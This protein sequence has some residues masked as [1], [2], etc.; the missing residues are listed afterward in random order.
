[1]KSATTR[2][3]ILTGI[4]IP[5]IFWGS[6]IIGASLHGNYNHFKDTI[7]QLGATGTRSETFMTVATWVCVILSV[8]F[9][10]G[11]LK[12]SHH[13]QI[14]KLPLIGV[15]GFT[16]IFGWAA[17]FHSGH[18][19]HSRSGPLLLLLLAGPLLTLILWKGKE[20][21]TPR[22]LSILS[23][24]FMLLILL[25]VVL[26]QTIRDNY[27]GLI[28]RSVHFGW[29]IWFISLVITFLPLT[30]KRSDTPGK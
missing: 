24:F 2:L 19:M 14:N 1:V 16:L 21:K 15:L 20:F 12:A 5:I 4:F 3:L 10:T 30:N 29:T 27:T 25:R 6:T 13:L 17:T 22:L 23:L 9:L 18:S 28:Q 11:L 8:V 26:S 7:S